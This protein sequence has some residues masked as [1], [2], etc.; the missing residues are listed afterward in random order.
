[1]GT[2]K[3]LV[4]IQNQIKELQD[5]VKGDFDKQSTELKELKENLSNISL[6]IKK[7][8]PTL[9]DN[10]EQCVKVE[11][12][13]PIVNLYFDEKGEI[14]YNPIFYSINILN[15]IGNEDFKKLSK[16]LQKMPKVKK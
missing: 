13:A 16:A 2:R 5:F 10:G 3:E 4:K 1:M 7:I 14:I 8:S 6:K 11:Y 12:E 9:L 15:L